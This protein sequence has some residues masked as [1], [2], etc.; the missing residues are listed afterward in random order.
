MGPTTQDPEFLQPQT[1]SRLCWPAA[2]EAVG[3]APRPARS[4][5]ATHCPLCNGETRRLSDQSLLKGWVSPG[6]G[7]SRFLGPGPRQGVKSGLG[8]GGPPP[9]A[10]PTAACLYVLFTV[11]CRSSGLKEESVTASVLTQFAAGKKRGT[12]EGDGRQLPASRQDPA[13]ELLKRTL[14]E[15][16]AERCHRVV[17]PPSR[18]PESPGVSVLAPRRDPRPARCV[19]ERQGPPCTGGSPTD[20][21]RLPWP[22]PALRAVP[23]SPRPLDAGRLPA[24]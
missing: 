20:V 11:M 5:A 16:H 3:G 8:D 1:K 10:T 17:P 12:S 19:R 6:P 24:C 15:R 14:C 4:L 23:A 9:H 7:L 2:A 22:T 18:C 13:R 21:L